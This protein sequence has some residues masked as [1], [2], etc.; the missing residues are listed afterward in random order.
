MTSRG[1]AKA[2][3]IQMRRSFDA[4][5]APERPRGMRSS[6]LFGRLIA[7]TDPRRFFSLG[8]WLPEMRAI[9]DE[10]AVALTFDDGPSAEVRATAPSS[11][12]A[13]ISGN[14]APRLKKRLGSVEAISLPNRSEDRI[15][16]GLSGA[17]KAS[18]ERRIWM[19]TALALPLEVIHAD[20]AAGVRWVA[21]E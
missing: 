4:F 18:N 2:V 5:S 10:G 21:T 17:L 11:S 7:S 13:R 20:A 8:A 9:E 16:R 1:S 3:N 19:F 6:D 12:I 14:Q 15:P